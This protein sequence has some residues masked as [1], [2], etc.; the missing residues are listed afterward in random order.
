MDAVVMSFTYVK[1]NNKIVYLQVMALITFLATPFMMSVG[2]LLSYGVL[3]PVINLH[4]H[5]C[6][7]SKLK[8]RNDE[9]RMNGTDGTRHF[10]VAV[11][12]LPCAEPSEVPYLIPDAHLSPPKSE[13]LCCAANRKLFGPQAVVFHIPES[14]RRQTWLSSLER[15][16]EI[17]RLLG[18]HEHAGPES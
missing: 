5:T 8:T 15:D 17:R 14:C 11:S 2:I 7:M 13:C 16:R 10:D 6:V 9:D 1:M 3:F 18:K 4:L 12:T